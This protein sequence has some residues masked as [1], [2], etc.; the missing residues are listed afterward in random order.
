MCRNRRILRN[1]DEIA[2]RSSIYSSLSPDFMQ[3]F[4]HHEL[5]STLQG[6]N[7]LDQDDQLRSE[8][9]KVTAVKMMFLA[10]TLALG[11]L[12]TMT[13]AR[14]DAAKAGVE[15]AEFGKLPDGTSV[16]IYTLTNAHG[17]VAKVMTLGATLTE[18]HVPDKA[19]AMGDIVLGFDNLDQY[20]KGCPYFGATV[21]RVANRI[22]K[23]KF[24]LD[25]KEFTLAVNNGPNSLH[26][27]LKGFDKVV[28]KAEEVKSSEGPSV[29]FSYHSPDGEE[30]YPGNLNVTVAYTLTN[31]DGLSLDYTAT[32]DKD[33]P[34][35][36]TN[37]TYFNLV[38]KGDVLS[39]VLW[40]N[41][42]HYTPVDDT[43]IPTGE[44]KAVAGTPMDFTT[45]HAI[46]D[47]MNEVPGEPKGY[48]H[49]YVLKGHLAARVME[50]TT[51]RVLEMH[52]TEP[53]VQFYTG[54]FL[55]GTLTGIGGVTYD[56]HT[57]FCLEAQHYPDSVNHPKFPPVILKP[58]KTYHQR[59][60]Y[61]FSV[62]K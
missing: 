11:V 27:G 18:L 22:A 30:G 54:N 58:G 13:S 24:T 51:G 21:G 46:G 57:A 43:Q 34:V 2:D 3:V 56:I 48:D 20:V 36:L 8:N 55:D 60:E 38:G 39:Y 47:H 15:K 31:K 9:V 10:A 61:D 44:V 25:G 52:T 32:T 49:N 29:K 59:T 5:N 37:H 41:A 62:A 23:G 19:G 53:G 14:G 45:P 1:P 7:P 26:G 12:T 40:L 33:T 16:D 42:D 4:R 35:N 28:W 17:L 6:L 50:P